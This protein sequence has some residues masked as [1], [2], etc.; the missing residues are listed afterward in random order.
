M[1]VTRPEFKDSAMTALVGHGRTY[2][3]LVVADFPVAPWYMFVF[4][5]QVLDSRIN[6]VMLIAWEEN[7]AQVIERT[8]DRC[9][10]AVYRVDPQSH[11]GLV[12]REVSFLWEASDRGRSEGLMALL[13]LAGT[14]DPLD[15][16]LQPVPPEYVGKLVYR[17]DRSA[18]HG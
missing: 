6:Q 2:W 15:S 12:F 10:R 14:S 18:A 16:F 7:L 4:E 8:S 13:A 11:G 17:S 1:F 9:R 5:G 3:R